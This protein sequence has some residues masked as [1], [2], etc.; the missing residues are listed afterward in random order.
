MTRQH[1]YASP[2]AGQV[3]RGNNRVSSKPAIKLTATAPDSSHPFGA[4]LVNNGETM[5]QMALLGL[6]RLGAFHVAEDIT[7]GRLV[8]LLETYNPGDLEA[9]QH[10][11]CQRRSNP[12]S[13][14]GFHRSRR[15]GTDGFSA[16]A[17]ELAVKRPMRLWDW[18]KSRYNGYPE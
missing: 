7:A 5:R 10:A 6:V 15:G 16:V 13:G 11:P 18:Q 8:P 14:A 4:N 12:P 1:H 3:H 2:A 17:S 9:D